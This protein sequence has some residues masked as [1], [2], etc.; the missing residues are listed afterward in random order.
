MSLSLSPTDGDLL[1]KRL[2]SYL[3]FLSDLFSN[4]QG[5]YE[6]VL[7]KISPNSDLNEEGRLFF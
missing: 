6:R 3:F 7:L 1:V 5:V 2:D 4:V